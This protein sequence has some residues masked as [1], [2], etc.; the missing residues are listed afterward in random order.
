RRRE[1][2]VAAWGV[3]TCMAVVG[4]PPQVA[5]ADPVTTFTDKA[6]FA[7]A[8]H[9]ATTYGYEGLAPSVGYN[10]YLSITLGPATFTNPIPVGGCL[11]PLPD[12]TAL[13]SAA[14]SLARMAYRSLAHRPEPSR[15][16]P[17]YW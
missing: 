2:V 16:E 3:L 7:A 11:F 10:A 15:S 13:K 6:A 4:S 5:Q 12:Q 14:G 1:F 17:N 9:D 8:I